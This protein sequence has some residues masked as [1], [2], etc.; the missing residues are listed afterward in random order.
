MDR[1]RT[2]MSGECA[3]PPEIVTAQAASLR[4]LARSLARDSHAAD[5][6]VQETW[7]R[8]L[9][10][11]PLERERIGGWL[12]R[13]ALGFA[14]KRSRSEARRAARERLYAC[15]R[16]EATSDAHTRA[17]TLRAVV[18]AVLSLEEPYRE[19]VLW[20]WFEGLPPRDIAV[21]QGTTVATVN[22]RLQRAH[23]RLREQLSRRLDVGEREL[24]GALL[25]LFGV[26]GAHTVTAAASLSFVGIAVSTTKMITGAALVAGVLCAFLYFDRHDGPRELLVAAPGEGAPKLERSTIDAVEGE[27]SKRVEAA[28]ATAAPVAAAQS[29]I[30]DRFAYDVT[31]VV[32]DESGRPRPRTSVWIGPELERTARLGETGWNGELHSIWRASEPTLDL[33]LELRG[34]GVTAG[35]LRRIALSAGAAER[36]VL[37]ADCEGALP[38]RTALRLSARILQPDMTDSKLDF[39]FG[40]TV[41]EPEFGTD[42][43]GNAVITDPW[44]MNRLFTAENLN[45]ASY[46]ATSLEAKFA[47]DLGFR[48]SVMFGK[49]GATIEMSA[50]ANKARIRGIAVDEI[51]QPIA[52]TLVSVYAESGAWNQHVRSNAEGAF[53][54]ADIPPGQVMILAGGAEHLLVRETLEVHEGDEREMRFVCPT[55]QRTRVKL[56]G[57]D[58]AALAQWRVEARRCDRN[59]TFVERV[60][61]DDEGRGALA[62]PTSE[63]LQLFAVP[64][65][66]A[67]T[68]PLLLDRAFLAD[69]KEALLVVR[70]DLRT[71]S[72]SIDA[73][74]LAANDHGYV[75]MRLWRVDSGLGRPAALADVQAIENGDVNKS[76]FQGEGLLPGDYLIEFGSRGTPWR[77]LGP[78]HVAPGA[79]FHLG[80]LVLEEPARVEVS[81]SKKDRETLFQ[82]STRRSGLR[83]QSPVVTGPLPA[84]LLLTAGEYRLSVTR[85]PKSDQQT[86]VTREVRVAS[87]ERASLDLEAPR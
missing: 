50:A 19:T 83:V 4:A 85:D 62:L 5:D 36:I 84:T 47:V 59:G 23:A 54:V 2:L 75:V 28:S 65:D 14:S 77:R 6:V 79:E 20:R 52:D 78:F 24:R 61:L 72:Y 8:A 27:A 82:A 1:T 80:P 46:L 26:E 40:L 9:T 67:R 53:E 69:G 10:S 48:E 13:V 43:A 45:L 12:R 15:E 87:D 3:L 56:V 41:G 33:V 76:T 70:D 31:F 7:L 37:A 51:A 86:Q 55:V 38:G 22:S 11:P 16:P 73:H 58:G 30:A 29:S 34:E 21:R 66:R 71:A 35:A 17:E 44:L 32:L 42:A 49:V 63:V 18:D 64:P 60:Q 57:A 81:A 25:A 74:C 39:G 68:P